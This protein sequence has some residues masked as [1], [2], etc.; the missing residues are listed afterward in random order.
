MY[1]NNV[2]NWEVKQKIGDFNKNSGNELG[3]G[4]GRDKKGRTKFPREKEGFNPE[5]DTFKRQRKVRK[6]PDDLQFARESVMRS[7]LLYVEKIVQVTYRTG[8]GRK[9]NTDEFL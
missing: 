6:N 8:V 4:P 7:L 9:M 2:R 1:A 5:T 3:P